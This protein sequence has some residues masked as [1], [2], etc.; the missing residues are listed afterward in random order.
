[1]IPSNTLFPLPKYRIEDLQM[2][3]HR[4]R[5][6][7]CIYSMKCMNERFYY[8]DIFSLRLTISSNEL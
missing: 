6:L 2:V 4:I 7:Q 1:M 5:K 3:L 8:F